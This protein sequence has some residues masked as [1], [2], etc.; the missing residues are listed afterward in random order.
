M[1]KGPDIPKLINRDIFWYKKILW[2]ALN[3]DRKGPDHD[4]F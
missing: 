1:A 3:L 2:D 4:K